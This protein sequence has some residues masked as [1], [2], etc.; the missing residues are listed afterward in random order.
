[1]KVNRK[2]ENILQ[3]ICEDL[4]L[5]TPIIN[6]VYITKEQLDKMLPYFTE[7]EQILSLFLF[8]S[9]TRF[10]T[11]A[12]S[13]QRKDIYEK[14]GETWINIPD[15]ISKSFGRTFN[16]IYCGDALIDY[17]NKRELKPDDYIFPIKNHNGVYDF[18]KKLKK[19][20]KKVLG[21]NISHPKARG[22]FDE[23]SGYDF[24]HSGAIHLRI[25]AQKN[26]SISLDAIRQRGGWADFKMLNYYTQLIG[27]DGEIKKESLL[28][29]EDRTKLEKEL[30]QMKVEMEQM[31]ITINSY[32][33]VLDRLVDSGKKDSPKTPIPKWFKEKPLEVVID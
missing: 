10:P 27:L 1:M 26:N 16:L 24:R 22:K 12:L 23:I 6:F 2:K 31:K 5:K 20:A 30:K 14:N 21:T 7:D 19:V 11:E 9:L 4:E 15:E 17:I 32:D 29:E 3:D 18:N 8:D 28:I 25:L 13:L 33:K